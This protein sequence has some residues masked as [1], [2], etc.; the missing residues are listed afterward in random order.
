M[1]GK[2]PKDPNRVVTLISQV[3]SS[4]LNL[5]FANEEF[6]NY[7]S[8]IDKYTAKSLAESSNNNYFLAFSRYC[9]FY[10]DHGFPS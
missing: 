2:T 8:K 5:N 7:H 10:S 4:S 1:F 6:T 3:R 9:R